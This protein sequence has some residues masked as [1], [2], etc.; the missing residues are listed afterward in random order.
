MGI[1]ALPTAAPTLQVFNTPGQLVVATGLG[2]FRWPFAATILG[3][4]L[5]IDTAP[6]GAA[7]LV[8]VNKILA[9]TPTVRTTIFTTQGNRPT[10]AI[11]AY[12]STIEAVPDITAYALGDFMTVDV[13]QIGSTVAGS[14]L[15]TIVRYRPLG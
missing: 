8:D 11:G 5:G 10:I 12:G 15:T 9:A 14:D 3:V 2:R 6:T 7:V 13:D 4:T 1:S